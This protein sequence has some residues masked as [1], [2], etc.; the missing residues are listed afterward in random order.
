MGRKSNKIRRRMQKQAKKE[1]R[2]Y[3]HMTNQ[4]IAV[5]K[6]SLKRN[7]PDAVAGL[8]ESF[9]DH[10]NHYTR[11]FQRKMLITIVEDGYT[12]WM[13][14]YTDWRDTEF[15]K[16]QSIWLYN[17]KGGHYVIDQLRSEVFLSSFKESEQNFKS[18]IIHVAKEGMSGFTIRGR[19]FPM[20][21]IYYEG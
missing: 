18:V 19:E 11:V 2:K 7:L 17:R 4:T 21:I 15:Q 12:E 20:D 1:K 6:A 10:H 14:N 8:L 16:K 3:Q 9:C 13:E 5:Y